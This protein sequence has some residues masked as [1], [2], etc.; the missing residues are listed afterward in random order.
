MIKVLQGLETCVP[1]VYS[2]IGKVVLCEVGSALEYRRRFN[3]VFLDFT[4]GMSFC[5]SKKYQHCS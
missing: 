4:R 2:A 5:V 3:S 1:A